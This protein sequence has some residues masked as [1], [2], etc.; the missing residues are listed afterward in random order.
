MNY[1]F[2]ELSVSLNFIIFLIIYW[3]RISGHAEQGVGFIRL[4]LLPQFNLAGQL[5]YGGEGSGPE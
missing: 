3:V 2:A 5:L 4:Q 1:S